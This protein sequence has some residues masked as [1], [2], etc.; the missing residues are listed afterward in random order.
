MKQKPLTTLIYNTWVQHTRFNSRD[1]FYYYI[2][3]KKDT[4][5]RTNEEYKK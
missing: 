1:A 5:H 2:L 3:Q 4:S